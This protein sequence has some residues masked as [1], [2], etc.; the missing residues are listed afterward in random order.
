MASVANIRRPLGKAIDPRGLTP[1]M[2]FILSVIVVVDLAIVPLA[3]APPVPAQGTGQSPTQSSATPES[4]AAARGV[5]CPAD[6]NAV[7]DPATKVLRC[8]RDVVSWVV[9]GCPDK[10]F[11]TYSARTGP[12][13]KSV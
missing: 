1:L 11:A 8:R 13:R 6:F 3:L 10:D 2:S 9:T 12:D 4:M 7:F 5:H